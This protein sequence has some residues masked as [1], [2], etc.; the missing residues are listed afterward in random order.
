MND[1]ERL[2]REVEKRRQAATNK[3]NRTRRATGAELT[4]TQ[5]D[6]R[7]GQGVEQRYNR[8][9][10]NSYLG[11]LNDFMRRSNQFTNSAG[12][13]VRAGRVKYYESLQKRHET[14]RQAHE[15]LIGGIETPSGRSIKGNNQM[16]Y[17]GAGAAVH[18]PYKEFNRTA[19]DI[20]GPAALEALIND[21]YKRINPNYLSNKIQQGRDNLKKA[22][23]V[24][25]KS[26]FNDQIDAL[27]DFQF[28]AFWYGTNI[29]ES[30]F[31]QYGMETERAASSLEDEEPTA[32]ERWQDRVVQDAVDELG[33]VLQWASTLPDG[34]GKT[35]KT[36]RRPR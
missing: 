17:K 4:G 10:L 7:R 13:P 36:P 24:I 15:E 19:M 22:L 20:R 34:S 5:F 26:E 27:S 11:Q 23:T 6:P 21:M 32:K 25:G 1:L 28:D 2:R 33:S 31:M 30:V 9:Q 16:L 29:A 8:A 18:G 3:I 14:I 12:G 35:K